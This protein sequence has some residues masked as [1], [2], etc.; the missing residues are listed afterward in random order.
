MSNE[1]LPESY[2]MW[3]ACRSES[4]LKYLYSICLYV[5]KWPSQVS[6]FTRSIKPFL[7]YPFTY[8]AKSISVFIL[9]WCPYFGFMLYHVYEMGSPNTNTLKALTAIVQSLAPLNSAANPVIYG[10]FSTRICRN[11][12]LLSDCITSQ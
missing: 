1:P 7:N 6:H 8:F 2:Q 10:V 4:S 12:R 9:C 5:E 3:Y 11:L